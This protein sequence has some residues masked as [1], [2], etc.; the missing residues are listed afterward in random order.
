MAELTD[1]IPEGCLVPIA[2]YTVN[3]PPLLLNALLNV[4]VLLFIHRF[5]GTPLNKTALA[6]CVVGAILNAS[7]SFIVPGVLQRTY[8]VAINTFTT[9]LVAIMAGMGNMARSAAAA[10]AKSLSKAGKKAANVDSAEQHQC[11]VWSGQPQ[12]MGFFTV[13]LLKEGWEIAKNRKLAAQH[14]YNEHQAN[15]AVLSPSD[16]NYAA[17]LGLLNTLRSTLSRA[18]FVLEHQMDRFATVQLYYKNACR[19]DVFESNT[20]ASFFMKMNDAGSAKFHDTVKQKYGE[21]TYSTIKDLVA[22]IK[23]GEIEVEDCAPSTTAVASIV[24][25]STAIV[26]RRGPGRPPGPG[27]AGSTK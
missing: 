5:A 8:Y 2:D 7:L 6:M 14:H 3:A 19:S 16:D 20:H 25:S 27:R 11:A 22:R 24:A 26:E 12:I 15:H 10:A 9:S 21:M 13:L 1:Y 17:S 18:E 4:L 23:A